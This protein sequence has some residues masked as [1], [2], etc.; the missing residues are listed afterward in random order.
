VVATIHFE[1]KNKIYHAWTD[2]ISWLL[3]LAD[4]YTTVTIIET[5]IEHGFNFLNLLTCYRMILR[6]W[7]YLKFND[8]DKVTG[9]LMAL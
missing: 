2:L 3:T 1:Q 4:T 7:L 8:T 5:L 6:I 9:L